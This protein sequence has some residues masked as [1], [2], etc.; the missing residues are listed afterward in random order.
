MIYQQN[1]MGAVHCVHQQ[2]D[3]QGRSCCSFAWSDRLRGGQPGD[4]NAWD[5]SIAS[6][7]LV[8]DRLQGVEITNKHFR[9][10][11]RLL[12]TH[13]T[14][15]ACIYAD[16]PYVHR[17]RTLAN[18]Y[19]VEMTDAEHLETTGDAYGEGDGSGTTVLISGYGDRDV[20]PRAEGLEARSVR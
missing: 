20:R 14:R 8:S 12:H 10:V 3:E 1:S 11:L 17:T 5:N 15:R 9:D 16:P 7:P 18:A 19:K 13:T 6:I 2:Q 4:L